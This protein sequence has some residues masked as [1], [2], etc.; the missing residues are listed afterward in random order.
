M[1]RPSLVVHIDE[2]VLDGVALDGAELPASIARQ[3]SAALVER[4][5]TSDTATS[6]SAAVGREAAQAVRGVRTR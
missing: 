6:T 2:L 5:L 4:G 1:K 3:V